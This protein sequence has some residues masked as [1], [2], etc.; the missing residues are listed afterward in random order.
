MRVVHHTPVW[1]ST[2]LRVN[3]AGD[4]KAGYECTYPLENGNGLCAGSVFDV[5]DAV[6]N[7]C[8]VV[9]EEGESR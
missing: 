2:E 5:A 3:A 9:L 4:S 1:E 7:H 6:S 8:C